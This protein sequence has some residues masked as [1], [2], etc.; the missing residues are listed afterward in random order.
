[1][2]KKLC[3]VVYP[4]GVRR[5]EGCTVYVVRLGPDGSRRMAKPCPKCWHKLEVEGVKAV[6]YTTDGGWERVR[7]DG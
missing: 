5:L 3:S 6:I 7:I 2:L 1:M 4:K